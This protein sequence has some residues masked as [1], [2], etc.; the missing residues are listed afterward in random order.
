MYHQAK[1]EESQLLVTPGAVPVPIR[2]IHLWK[3][4]KTWEDAFEFDPLMIYMRAGKKKSQSITRT[5][6]LTTLLAEKRRRTILTVNG[7]GAFV[8]AFLRVGEDGPKTPSGHL[9]T[10]IMSQILRIFSSGA[11]VE[12]Q[13]RLE[14]AKTK[15]TVLVE[16]TIGDRL[17]DM[18]YI[19]ILATEPASQGRGY[20]GAL[21]EAIN[22]M[23]DLC[24]KASWLMA[25]THNVL[26][27]NSHGYQSAGKCYMGEGNPTWTQEPIVV[28]M[29][30][31]EARTKHETTPAM[32]KCTKA[33]KLNFMML[34][35]ET[36]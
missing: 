15:M 17:S 24:G 16:E 30:I 8:I 2:Y 27:Y 33:A 31:R 29:M 10:W 21:V 11:T 14:E 28:Y 25:I 36:F 13:K 3:A 9:F 20:G 19:D 26:F 12:Q 4:A 18:V 32:P 34:N 6:N 23:A 1:D 35:Y 22:D 5:Q 7:G